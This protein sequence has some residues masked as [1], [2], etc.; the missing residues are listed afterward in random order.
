MKKL[1]ILLG[2]AALIAG[3]HS[4]DTSTGGTY[5]QTGTM[6]GSTRGASTRPTQTDQSTSQGAGGAT[7][8]NNTN[9]PPNSSQSPQNNP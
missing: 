2:S 5:D 8:S 7:L 3:C 9:T 1:I 6:T 4:H